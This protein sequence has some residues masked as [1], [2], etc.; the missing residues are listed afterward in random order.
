MGFIIEV[1]PDSGLVEAVEPYSL[2]TTCENSCF[3]LGFYDPRAHRA[4][5][6]NTS[7]ALTLPL[8]AY[9]ERMF[10]HCRSPELLKA[11]AVGPSVDSEIHARKAREYVEGMLAKFLAKER[12][13]CRW[14]TNGD[15]ISLLELEIS[16]GKVRATHYKSNISSPPP[17][18]ASF[19]LSSRERDLEIAY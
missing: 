12:I 15:N 1:Q 18:I 9:L 5:M 8:D 4:F 13:D 3:G 14:R 7:H 11:V 10:E 2:Q 17:E 19:S 6:L 16:K